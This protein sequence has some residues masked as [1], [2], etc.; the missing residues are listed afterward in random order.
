M[1]TH[2]RH[3]ASTRQCNWRLNPAVGTVREEMKDWVAGHAALLASELLPLIDTDSSEMPVPIRASRKSC[4][5]HC[6]A[7]V[8][9]LNLR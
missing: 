7:A 3:P 2:A 9:A 6:Y 8:R 1:G 4:S 5:R